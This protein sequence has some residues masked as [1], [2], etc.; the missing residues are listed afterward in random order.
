ME[1]KIKSINLKHFNKEVFSYTMIS[2]TFSCM[3]NI[4]FSS[5]SGCGV[6]TVSCVLSLFQLCM[7]HL[8]T[9]Y[10]HTCV[11]IMTFSFFHSEYIFHQIPLFKMNPCNDF[12]HKLYDLQ[13]SKNES[14]MGEEFWLTEMM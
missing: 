11:F 14:K 6:L 3:L 5:V 2:N 10:H 8:S 9:V 7:L 13:F 12:T 1:E 4:T